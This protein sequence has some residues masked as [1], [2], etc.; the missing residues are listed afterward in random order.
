M[1]KLFIA[2]A[3][4]SVLMTAFVISSVVTT[5]GDTKAPEDNIGTADAFA[6]SGDEPLYTV[7]EYLERI[8]IFKE[9][10]DKP[11]IVLD[12][13]VFTLPDADRTMLKEG[14]II[15]KDVLMSTIEDYT[16]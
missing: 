16:G 11:D 5:T 9:G 1:K 7:K 12:V 6:V 13:Y 3:A 15:S 2:A 14:F 10:K 4:F 8:G